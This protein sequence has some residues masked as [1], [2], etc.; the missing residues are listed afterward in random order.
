MTKEEHLLMISLFTKQGQFIKTLVAI[1]KSRG[2]LQ[3]DDASAFAFAT[4][5][6]MESNVALYA[7]MRS[8]YVTLAKGLGIETGLE[9]P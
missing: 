7:E 1:M 2:I 9:N 4:A 6:D 5:L 8:A 3:A